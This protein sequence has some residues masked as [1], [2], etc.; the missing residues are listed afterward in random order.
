M[1]DLQRIKKII[2]WLIFSDFGNNETEIAELLGYTKSSFSQIMNGK[3]PVSN[4]FIDKICSLDK[5][6]NKVWIETGEGSIFVSNSVPQNIDDNSLLD[7][8]QLLKENNSLKTK[9]IERL[10]KELLLSKKETK[11]FQND[12]IL[13]TEQYLKK[14]EDG[15]STLINTTSE[16]FG[17]ISI[18]DQETRFIREKVLEVNKKLDKLM[19]GS[20]ISKK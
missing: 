19:A 11:S 7:Q 18:N 14:I 9:E 17:F 4:K 13:N 20:S 5:N 8:I 1:T 6:I 12:N 15:L 16:T 3:V 10:E 2:K